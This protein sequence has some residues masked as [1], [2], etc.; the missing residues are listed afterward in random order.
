MTA[1]GW[2]QK[3]SIKRVVATFLV[4][5]L[6]LGAFHVLGIWVV[7]DGEFAPGRPA[8]GPGLFNMDS[9]SAVPTWW[10]I[11]QHLM[12][13][14]LALA[15]AVGSRASS[16]PDYRFW[17]GL[18]GIFV[19]MSMDE[20]L[21]IHGLTTEPLRDAFGITGGPL[22]FAWLLIGA[23]A[24]VILGAV[25]FRFWLRLPQRPR[26]LLAI[27]GA[28]FFG[29]AFGLEMVGGAYLGDGDPTTVYFIIVGVEETFELIG[30][31][32]MISSL[33]WMLR[34]T[35]QL[36]PSTFEIAE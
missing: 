12:A 5:D 2:H 26:W 8:A 36:Q 21:E 16:L 24:A 14:A 27:G 3:I 30:S 15:I 33:L 9:V 28:V 1:S 32:I 19:F 17:F 7:F 29:G 10:A 23:T 25:Y 18:G 13:A 4:V 34:C 22:F 20:S 35:P 31:T 6:V 11:S